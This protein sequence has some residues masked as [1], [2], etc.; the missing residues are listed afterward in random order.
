MTDPQ[1]ST[2]KVRPFVDNRPE[3][4]VSEKLRDEV[5]LAFSLPDAPQVLGSAL[6]F[7]GGSGFDSSEDSEKSLIPNPGN[8]VSSIDPVNPVDYERFINENMD[9]IQ[10]D[11]QSSLLLFPDQDVSVKT[12][13][14]KF[15]TVAFPVPGQAKRTDDTLVRD[16]VRFFTQDWES[17]ERK[18]GSF[19]GHDEE[20][21]TQ[22]FS[23]CKRTA[24]YVKSLPHHLYEVDMSQQQKE[25][26]EKSQEEL[27]KLYRQSISSNVDYNLDGAESDKLLLDLLLPVDYVEM[28]ELNE[29][30]RMANRHPSLFGLYPLLGSEE[31]LENRTPSLPPMEN[32]SLRL[33][34]KISELR[35][36]LEF[37]PIF[38]SMALYDARERRK[39]SE[40]SHLDCNPSEINHMLD[41]Y[42]EERSMASLSRQNIFNI[43]YPHNDIFLVVKV[44]KVL[45]QG[46]IGD[47]AEPYYRG[48]DIEKK[49]LDKVTGNAKTF[50]RQLGQYRMPFAWAAINVIDLIAG[51]Q[52]TSGASH[53]AVITQDTQRERVDSTSSNRKNSGSTTPMGTQERK[54]T[55]S[56][57]SRKRDSRPLSMTSNT[58]R[59][60]VE[61]IPEDIF[62][63][64][65]D[66]S[67]VT[68]TLNMFIKQDVDKLKDDDLYRFLGDMRKPAAAISRKFKIIPGHLKMDIQPPYDGLPCCLTSNL[69]EVEPF[70][71]SRT[72]RPI[73]EIEEFPSRE[74]YVPHTTYKN[75]LYVYPHTLDLRGVNKRNIGIKVQFMG[76]EEREDVLPAIYGRSNGPAFLRDWWCLVQYHN[77]QPEFY[78]EIK[79]ELPPKITHKHH[80]LFSFYH[81]SC[82]KPKPEIPLRQEPFFLGCTWIPLLQDNEMKIGEFNL[83]L[84]ADHPPAAYSQ[85]SSDVHLPNLKWIDN[86]RPLFRVTLQMISSIYPQDSYLL[87]FLNHYYNFNSMLGIEP[88]EK[89]LV[90]S[91]RQ[92]EEA[93]SEPLVKFLYLT[94]NSLC[95]LLVRPTVNT[96]SAEVP[97]AAFS[98]LAHIVDRIHE[99]KLTR[100]KHNRDC[101]LCSYVQYVFSGPQGPPNSSSFDPRHVTAL[102]S[103]SS[104]INEE[105]GMRR[106]SSLRQGK[107]AIVSP[108]SPP[109]PL[110]P[111]DDVT[112][113]PQTTASFKK[114]FYE[115][116]VFSWITAHP[117]TRPVVYSNAWFFFELLI[118]S[119]AQQLHR[120]NKLDGDRRT[121]F[122]QK[123]LKDVEVLIGM[124]SLEIAEKHIQ[125]VQYARQL[126]TS[127]AFFIHDCFSLV[128]RG[129]VF[130]LIK[131]YL[132]KFAL[133]PADLNLTEFKLDFYRIV[134]SHEHYVIL[135]LPLGA[136]LYPMGTGSQSSSPTGSISSTY[137]DLGM[138]NMDAMGDLSQEFRHYHYLSGLVLSELSGVLE[139]KHLDHMKMKSKLRE[140]AVEVLRD[141]LSAHDS[142]V[143]YSSVVAR[144]RIASIYLPLL[145]VVMDNFH[146]L[147]KGADG[148]D[149]LTSTFDRNTEVRRS[150]VIKEDGSL[151]TED[152][153][154]QSDNMLGPAS[155]RNL[156]VCF[157]WVLKNIE[158]DLL[159]HWWT[160][161][162]ISKLNLLLNVLDLCVA[163]FEYKGKRNL[164]SQ[165]SGIAAMSSKSTDV[166]NR[167]TDALVSGIGT[168]KERLARRRQQQILEQAGGSSS[169]R[170]EKKTYWQAAAEQS[171]KPKGDV[172]VDAQIE[173]SLAGEAS[174]IV[175]D[176]IELLVSNVGS[177]ENLQSVL[178]KGLEV[179][180]HL[181]FCNQSVEVMKCI[182]A[183]QRAIVHKFPE[184]IFFEET[185][186]CA[187][188]CARLLKHC[189]SS[190]SDIRAWACA[191]LYLLMRQ[192]FEIGNNFA[193]VKV[194]VTVALSSIVAGTASSF[195]EH[196]LR[197]SLKTLIEYADKDI[198]MQSSSF[199]DQV[200]EL[201][202]NLH[203]ILLDTVKMQSFQNDP[204][205]LMDLMYRISKGYQNSP[206]LR[207]TWLQHMAKNHNEREHY[208][209]AAMCL[210]HAAALVAEYLYMLDGSPYLPI[211]CVTFQKISPNMLEES[212]ISDDVIN[213]E[214]EGIATSKLFSE[215]GLVGLLEQAAPLFRESQL[216]EAASEV[217]KLVIPI[218][219]Q[220]R[221]YHSMESIY[222][223]LS[224]CFKNLSKKGDKRFLGSYF[225]V[226]FYGWMFG[227][228]HLKEFIYKDEALMKL[229]EFSLKLE[230]LYSEQ[231]GKD[232]IE[233]I[234][235][236][237]DVDHSKLSDKKAYIQ[238]TYVDPYFE[239]WELKD[240]RTI[241]DKMFNIRRFS[242]STPFTKGG[243]ARGELHEQ[244]M[245]KTILTTEKSFPYVKRRLE[246]IH[247]ERVELTPLEVAILNMESKIS[248]LK[249]V[250]NRVPCD[251]KLLQMQLQGGF[252][253]AVNQGPFAIAKCFLED[254]PLAEQTHVHHKL[255]VCFKEFTKRC[256]E[257]LDRNEEMLGEER[258]DYQKELTRKFRDFQQQLQ[259]MVTI[260]RKLTHGKKARERA[261]MNISTVRQ[262]RTSQTE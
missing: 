131:C 258:Y 101:I 74:V 116:L 189:S 145:S 192:N 187:E 249:Y 134:C 69:F 203:H 58:S 118:K 171:K 158:P 191:S 105:D 228:L 25:K 223:K 96:E 51:S 89:S 70:P 120:N 52:T 114:L 148:W 227:D 35:F 233:I 121:R 102:R 111:G 152:I 14:R 236:S 12:I 163:C 162:S 205:M 146:R 109:P 60:I 112:D 9:V 147:Y 86:H 224:D 196:H 37:E 139:G 234:K 221:Q 154:N 26:E 65:Q 206:D 77:K 261:L 115:E 168:A 253:T 28:D 110:P 94:L 181:M 207:L 103:R 211:G 237:N 48:H 199:P 202:I 160:T 255:K 252:A 95:T 235:D 29:S 135:N 22:R 208:T 153:E 62:N 198:D 76:G 124:V 79:I 167:L 31:A 100:D 226:G 220:R 83:A 18:Y 122:T 45:Q 81:V 151:E 42:N 129:F 213:P 123:Y 242:F 73:K 194:Q 243:K 143:R 30:E 230:T 49:A 138:P 90:G 20:F 231:L 217:Y 204:E 17:I 87:S 54:N 177:I 21:L 260:H 61:E 132:K 161:L 133:A 174:L 46:D 173:A 71:D 246:V 59:T 140:Q 68:L 251:T 254:V 144:A 119:M 16:C 184:L 91:V 5:K 128:D 3:R 38:A 190:I 13:P 11:S 238:V 53:T 47:A 40:S 104:F 200:R 117:A 169:L 19:Y 44:E 248:D 214:E 8:M 197:R 7:V 209:E 1:G 222:N 39:I 245:K 6:S 201:A 186:Q 229:S 215:N 67:P 99:L 27:K 166:K 85:L 33:L 195:N 108:T 239:E 225:R 172:E 193:R 212:A 93:A 219:E 107:H 50:C 170:W 127:L 182:F 256:Q 247:T 130:S 232:K 41:D 32:E 82:Q 164:T 84:T 78:E 165:V 179:L 75:F 63:I 136:Q 106:S 218:Y 55:M 98:S 216:Y 188:L 257:G 262:S 210:V 23:T 80:L 34:I 178:G 92:L 97:R 157:L 142:D 176:T 10:G 56:D 2:R 180:L 43:T 155:T 156:L 150:V 141:L 250:L 66:F 4:G 241:F 57:P 24:E 88:E 125:H 149:N 244:W 113:G 183:T 137:D 240:R 126:N 64:T 259:P 185:E 15:R 175:L 36:D 72:R 159:H